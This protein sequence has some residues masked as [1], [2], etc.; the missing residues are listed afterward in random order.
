[1]AT[2]LPDGFVE[3]EVEETCYLC[4]VTRKSNRVINKEITKQHANMASSLLN[5]NNIYKRQHLDF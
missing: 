2:R 3:L 1:M 4:R 5:N